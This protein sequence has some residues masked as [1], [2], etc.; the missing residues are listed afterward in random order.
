MSAQQ[1]V[2]RQGTA[3]TE[4]SVDLVL[5]TGG[6]RGIGRHL[7]EAFARAGYTVVLTATDATRAQATAAEL[8][9]AAGAPQRVFGCGLDV[10][11]PGS[12]TALRE[13]LEEIAARTGT[14]LR[15]LVNN[16]GRIEPNA[17]PVWEDDPADLLA[18][19]AAN[20]AGP[21]LLVNALAPVLLATAATT[22]APARIID[23]NSGS[24]AQ[25]TV[26]YAAYS[27]SKAALFRLADSVE[28]YGHEQGLRI[29]EMAPGVVRTEM[30]SAMSVHD[31]RSE[32]TDPQAV[33]DLALAFASG[34]LDAWSGRYVRAGLDTPESL[35]AASPQAGRRLLRVDM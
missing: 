30:T 31:G 33:A 20:V 15:V 2:G 11:D 6:A 32:W 28:H 35:A 27:A 10:A 14:R 23:L 26:E 22:G 24:G 16:A 17:G 3:G 19:V 18:V 9:A 21:L 7:A 8:A 4:H 1:A 12:V 29:F 5:I 34:D 13:S 25:G